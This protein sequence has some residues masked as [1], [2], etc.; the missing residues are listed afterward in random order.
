MTQHHYA[1]A[2]RDALG[3]LG[4]PAAHPVAGATGARG[5]LDFVDAMRGVAALAVALAHALPLSGLD[6]TLPLLDRIALGH[7]GVM[8]FFLCSGFVI[9]ISL[10]RAGL[11]TF[12]VRRAL[13]LY[14]AY[15][16]TIALA[17]ALQFIAGMTVISPEALGRELAPAILLNLTMLQELLGAPNLL[18]LFWTLTIEMLFYLVVTLLFRLRVHQHSALIAAALLAAAAGLELAVPRLTG[19]PAGHNLLF[20]IGM[21]FLGTCFYRRGTGALGG[22]R[23]AAVVAGAL[24]TALLAWTQNQNTPVLAAWV[25]ALGLFGASFALRARPM[26]AGLLWLGQISYSLYLLH[27]LVYAVVPQMAWPGLT[28]LVWV[29]TALGLAWGSYQLFER[30]AIAL[31]RR[32]TT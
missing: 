16:V 12:W 20:Y 27:G 24:A 2:E 28:I 18:G 29:G 26:A 10:E 31:G 1:H 5:R 13:R 32:L 14:P 3:L 6:K 21:M 4:A 17:L 9:P 7:A 8:L 30:P 25:V 11:R 19:Q 23:L 15:W 22:H